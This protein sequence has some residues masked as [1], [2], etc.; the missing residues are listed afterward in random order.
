[1]PLDKQSRPARETGRPGADSGQSSSSLEILQPL[2]QLLLEL[3]PDMPVSIAESLV[4]EA[5]DNTADA[6]L[7]AQWAQAR[8]RLYP[9]AVAAAHGRHM[10]PYAVRRAREM[11]AARLYR[12]ADRH[13]A[14]ACRCSRCL[15]LDLGEAVG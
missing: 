3:R 14:V 9:D 1:M 11:A 7:D 12:P 15:P 13:G 4:R 8:A 2:A 10:L 5:L 6:I